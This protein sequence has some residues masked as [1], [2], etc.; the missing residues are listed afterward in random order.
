[1]NNSRNNEEKK[2]GERWDV[3]S[4]LEEGKLELKKE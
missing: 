4:L 3:L 2:N 1:V